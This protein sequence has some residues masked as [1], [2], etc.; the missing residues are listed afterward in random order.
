MSKLNFK[1][2][3]QLRSQI[4]VQF[5]QGMLDRMFTS[6]YRYGPIQEGF[7]HKV[8]AIGC[9][10]M[11][12]EK[13]EETGNTEWLMDVSNFAMIEFTLPKHP[14]AHF[15]ATEGHESPGGITNE[16]KVF[17]KQD[18]PYQYKKDGD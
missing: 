10:K 11:R 17:L 16:G 9:L 1:V 13:Y 8:D 12:L 18:E 3:D 15:R 6:F 7:P 5:I 2:I 14:K 4:N